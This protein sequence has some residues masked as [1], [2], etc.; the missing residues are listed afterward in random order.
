MFNTGMP[1]AKFAYS[2][3]LQTDTLKFI[4]SSFHFQEVSHYFSPTRKSSLGSLFVNVSSGFCF[5]RLHGISLRNC[6]SLNK[7]K[8]YL[9]L[10]SDT[11]QGRVCGSVGVVYLIML[12]MKCCCF[13][14]NKNAWF[15]M[16]LSWSFWQICWEGKHLL[17]SS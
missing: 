12:C 7:E 9:V 11:K 4:W 2:R 8:F 13:C 5:S 1:L 3:S 15:D 17:F 14:W 16:N 10:T 6:V